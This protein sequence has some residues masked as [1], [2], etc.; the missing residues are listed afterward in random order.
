VQTEDGDEVNFSPPKDSAA[1]KAGK[2]TRDKQSPAKPAPAPARPISFSSALPIAAA[3]AAKKK[4]VARAPF[5]RSLAVHP[6]MI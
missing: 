3:P 1:T 2:K 5:S 6:A 4:K